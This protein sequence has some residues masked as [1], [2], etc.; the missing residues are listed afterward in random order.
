MTGSLA[1]AAANVLLL[2]ALQA[3]ARAEAVDKTALARTAAGGARSTVA[4]V[5]AVVDWANRSLEWT[6][7][8]YKQRTVDA[9]LERKGGNCNDQA[10][11]V[12]ALLHE[13]GIETRRVREINVQPESADRQR[14]AERRVK[15]IGPGASVFGL[16]H[17][18]HVW[19]EFKD[20]ESSEW[21]PADPTLNLVGYEAWLKA[22]VGFGARPTSAILPSRDMLVPLAVFATDGKAFE[23]RSERYLLR[24]FDD[25]Y[26]G[27]LE[28]LPAWPEWVRAVV[29]V[30]P[31]ALAAFEG[32]ASLHAHPER[33][34]AV[35]TAWERLR[36]QQSGR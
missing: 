14:N 30:E 13:L 8:D 33:I 28:K 19:I 23:P 34:L 7:T 15:E 35:Q 25:L 5:R 20:A 6:T 18:D 21:T 26:G 9:I 22:R 2:A 36:A 29:D 10:L 4:K 1:R 27:A 3:A 17:N 11:V 24:G 12:A 31:D 16:R 32:R